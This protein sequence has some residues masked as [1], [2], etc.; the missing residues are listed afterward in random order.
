VKR[1]H[2]LLFAKHKCGNTKEECPHDSCYLYTALV[3][4]SLAFLE[5]KFLQDA[6]YK[7]QVYPIDQFAN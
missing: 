3:V 2:T 5:E 1:G 6:S 7:V 4:K